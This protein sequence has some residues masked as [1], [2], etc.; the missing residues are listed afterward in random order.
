MIF[1]PSGAAVLLCAAV[2]S[3]LSCT[4]S[5]GAAA[6]P[7][8]A[9]QAG[10]VGPSAAA[11]PAPAADDPKVFVK[12]VN[13]EL[14][15]L[16]VR[17]ST[18]EWIK[19]TYIT[20]DSERNAAWAN[21]AVMAY[22]TDAIKK[23]A[24]FKDVK[25]DPETERMLYLLR[26]SSALPAPS[27][28]AKRRELAQI[29]S[30][31]EGLYGKGKYC[32]KDG[33]GTCRD[34]LELEK[35]MAES[36]SS[37]QLLE[38]WNGWHSIA[39]EMRPL[40]QRL[41]GLTN[42]GAREIGF[43]DL[44]RLWRSGYDMSPE[45]FEQE[46]DRLW[47]QVKPLY[48]D[49]HCYVR[50][51]L[52]KKYGKERV[53][54]GEPIPAHLLGNMWAQDWANVYSL[55]EPYKGA[56]SIDVT[57]AIRRQKRDWKWMV[58]TSEAFFTSLG[59]NELP[60]TF[61]E[62][63]LFT[64]PRDRE[65]V[66]HASAWDVTYSGDLRIKMCIQP[67]HEDLVVIHHEL[68]HV[69]YFNYYHTLPVLFQNGANE[70]FHEAIGDAL[71]LSITPGYLVQLGLA[72]SL[73]KDQKGLINVQMRDA[74]AKVAFLPFGKLI[75]QWR[76]DVF[77]GKTSPSDYNASWWRLREKYQGVSTPVPRSEQDFDPGAKYH[78]PANVPYT[79]Y[80]LAHLLQFQFHRALCQAS[81]HRGPLHEC[82]I[83]GNKEAGA[84]LKTLLEMGAS[85]PWPD[86]LAVLTG[87]RQMDATA[88]LDYFRPLQGWLSEQNKGRRCGW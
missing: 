16:I 73:P 4:S 25:T 23:A 76:W 30:R 9:S 41:V 17:A 28:P 22:L 8:A 46:T 50:A 11:A 45:A 10:A 88:L 12:R 32:G 18:A 75:D 37:D 33:K 83:Y 47:E 2:T 42:E 15:D 69:Y 39:P 34:L 7:T 31:L 14:K 61:W 84:R 3:S 49:L 29:A 40:Y 85:K 36:R 68:G 56:S 52:Q 63:S 59:M 62:R 87:E 58:K 57:A 71:A 55:V 19:S 26:V 6:S 27:D 74:L 54:D 70:G 64:K 35:V 67:T 77:A 78:I 51:Q 79:R 82:S 44:G 80:F 13:E 81:G 20:D 43:S 21:E 24:Q 38:A 66:C 60:E 72:D 65:V 86:A 53:P 5:Q 48:V 1:R